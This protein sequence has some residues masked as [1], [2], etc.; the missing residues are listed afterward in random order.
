MQA[1]SFNPDLKAAIAVHQRR[2]PSVA[3]GATHDRIPFNIPT[4]GLWIPAG[5]LDQQ[6]ARFVADVDA[7]KPGGLIRVFE[8]EADPAFWNHPEVVEA[9]YRAVR[10]NEALLR[11]YNRGT[12][13]LTQGRRE[14]AAYDYGYCERLVDR[15]QL[16]PESV[17]ELA[18]GNLSFLRDLLGNTF[19][20]FAFVLMQQGQFQDAI[21]RL[22]K[23][24]AFNPTQIFANNN[25]GDCYRLTGHLELARMHYA[26]EIEGN[27]NHPTAKTS[28]AAL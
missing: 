8:A 20:N 17:E 5:S 9:M 13:M 10:P 25:L 26:K 19:N 15:L 1:E 18:Q 16:T 4:G 23:A 27:P 12:E 11:H 24:L 3:V 6:V 14:D 21:P 28:L 22:Q 7:V 2:F